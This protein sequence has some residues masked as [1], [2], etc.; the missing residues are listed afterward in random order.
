MNK[1][2]DSITREDLLELYVEKGYIDSEV[3]ELF[4]V[5]KE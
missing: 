2:W 1:Q 4:G 3:A 5:T